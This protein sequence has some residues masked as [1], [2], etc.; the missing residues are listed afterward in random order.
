MRLVRSHSGCCYINRYMYLHCTYL[1]AC[2][3]DFPT[4]YIL[5]YW[6]NLNVPTLLKWVDLYIIVS[7]Q[8]NHY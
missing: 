7:I 6:K 4:L 8:W 1:I 2:L 5:L 3:M